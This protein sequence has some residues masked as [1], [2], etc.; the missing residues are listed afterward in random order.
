MLCFGYVLTICVGSFVSDC[1][2]CNAENTESVSLFKIKMNL[3]YIEWCS[4]AWVDLTRD[5]D[6]VV[7]SCECTNDL[8]VLSNRR[9][10]LS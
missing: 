4:V 2:T 7:G 10:V 1:T 3:Q 5:K 9:N 6:K 8:A